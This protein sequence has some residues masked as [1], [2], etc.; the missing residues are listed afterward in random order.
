MTQSADHR[1]TEHEIPWTI[2]LRFLQS[3]VLQGRVAVVTTPVV[4]LL[5]RIG[6]R[7]PS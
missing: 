7:Q 5:R 3:F 4:D 2:S 6:C 1:G